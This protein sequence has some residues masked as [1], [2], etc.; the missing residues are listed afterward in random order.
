MGDS[1]RSSAIYPPDPGGSNKAE[2]RTGAG[3]TSRIAASALSRDQVPPRSM[4]VEGTDRRNDGLGER[5]SKSAAA[6]SSRAIATARGDEGHPPT[7]SSESSA[8]N[9][10]DSVSVG[11]VRER[12]GVAP[13]RP[14]PIISSLVPASIPTPDRRRNSTAP[15]VASRHL[16]NTLQ[17]ATS[18]CS[19]QRIAAIAIDP[20]SEPSDENLTGMGCADNLQR[21]V[22]FLQHNQALLPCRCKEELGTVGDL[23]RRQAEIA[24][25]VVAEYI[26]TAQPV[27][28]EALR[29]NRGFD[30]SSA[31]I[32]NEMALL[33]QKGYLAQPHT[34]AGRVPLGP[35]YRLYVNGLQPLGG[36]LDRDIAWIQG[37]L[38]R[39]G[40]QRE[41]ALRLSTA[42]LSRATRYPA[43][44]VASRRGG[45][46][47]IDISLTPISA[48]NVLLSYL[49]DRGNNEEALIEIDGS[50][51]ADQVAEVENYLRETLRGKSVGTDVDPDRFDAV[52][53]DLLSGVGEA[54]DEAGTG[55]VYVEGTTYV[56]DQPEFEQPE[57]LRRV[58]GTLTHSPLLRRTLGTV[59]REHHAR[60]CI[61][62]EHGVEELS[63]CSV[64]ASAYSV[65]RR[66]GGSV[67]VLGPMRMHYELAMEMVTTI[68]RT[69]TQ[70]LSRESEV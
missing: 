35:A 37:E 7:S 1:P 65:D 63:D 16:R 32:R 30:C 17:G 62:G 27:G 43:V 55:R 6:G 48:S 34:S 23:T 13:R 10:P 60:A 39:V 64:V 45:P 61:G 29:S 15:G 53:G 50:I 54:L 21:D 8:D 59:G 3:L 58:I 49:D 18:R 67:G 68:A 25:A 28:S 11:G 31:T 40:G 46:R 38:R 56:L 4:E 14:A 57:S 69:L 20:C 41:A 70:A 33:E 36:R 44:V 51:R 12:V 47:L 2:G 26:D 24:T 5:L 9:D 42:I 52:E 19:F 22:D 66:R